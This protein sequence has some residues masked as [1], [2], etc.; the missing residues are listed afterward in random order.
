MTVAAPFIGVPLAFFALAAWLRTSAIVRMRRALGRQVSSASGVGLYFGSLSV[1]ILT[2]LLFIG[3]LAIATASWFRVVTMLA[4]LVTGRANMA[5]TIDVIWQIL[6]E[7]TIVGGSFV[8]IWIAAQFNR[9][10]WERDVE[11]THD[12]ARA[13]R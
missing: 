2:L 1:V 10:A 11:S 6:I 5:P 8:M 4:D 12:G 7:V 13:S 3:G 9:R